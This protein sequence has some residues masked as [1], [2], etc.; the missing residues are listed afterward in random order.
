MF[1]LENSPF[2]W[3]LSLE[4]SCTLYLQPLINLQILSILDSPESEVSSANSWVESQI[5]NGEEKWAQ[6]RVVVLVERAIYE[7]ALAELS[8]PWGRHLLSS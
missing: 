7:D 8:M 1:S 2:F 6:Q 4:R 3:A 5:D